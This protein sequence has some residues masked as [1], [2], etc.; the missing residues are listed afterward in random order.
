MAKKKSLFLL[1][2]IALI[3]FSVTPF[4]GTCREFAI[5][6][7]RIQPVTIQ[8]HQIGINKIDRNGRDETEQ[9]LRSLGAPSDKVNKLAKAV[10]LASYATGLKEELF[11]ALMYTE[12]SFKADAV[13]SKGYKGLLQ[14]PTA[15]FKY[16]EVDVMHGAMILQD[17]LDQTHG[18]LLDAL[19]LYKGGNNPAAKKYA[20]QT[21]SL[22]V[23]LVNS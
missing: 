19:A 23:R 18:N 9:M 16:A 10:R 14:T 21:Y 8:C 5:A 3:V 6:S 15:T 7:D 1:E 4:A 2:V 13:S 22:Y 17:K 11:V 12:S 20:S